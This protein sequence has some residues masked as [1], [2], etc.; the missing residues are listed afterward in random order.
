VLDTVGDFG[1]VADTAVDQHSEAAHVAQRALGANEL[2]RDVDKHFAT[3]LQFGVELGNAVVQIHRIVTQFEQLV[4][5]AHKVLRSARR[6]HREFLSLVRL[7]IEVRLLSV[8]R[9][10]P[11][12]KAART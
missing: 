1:S 10:F 11:A 3:L 4:D 5:A 7:C 8:S 2:L 9:S 6:T 12:S